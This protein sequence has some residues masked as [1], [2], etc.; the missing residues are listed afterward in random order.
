MGRRFSVQR[1]LELRD[2]LA[3]VLGMALGFEQADDVGKAQ[4]HGYQ[5]SE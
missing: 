4:A 5:G 1:M 2:G 3:V